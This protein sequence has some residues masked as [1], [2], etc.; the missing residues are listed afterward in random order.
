MY[1]RSKHVLSNGRWVPV[2]TS[3]ALRAFVC[4]KM[5]VIQVV[6]PFYLVLRIIKKRNQ[7]RRCGYTQLTVNDIF[8]A[9]AAHYISVSE[10]TVINSLISSVRLQ[11]PSMNF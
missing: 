3:V 4:F 11:P 8:M 10:K 6:W 2:Q 9:N 5:H 1:V 7:P